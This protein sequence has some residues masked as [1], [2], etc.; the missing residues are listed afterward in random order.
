[1]ESSALLGFLGCRDVVACVG[2]HLDVINIGRLLATC[3]SLHAQRRMIM[4]D[5][6]LARYGLV[7]WRRA[8]TRLT[9]QRPLGMEWE[10]RRMHK[11]EVALRARGMPPWTTDDYEAWWRVEE[12]WLSGGDG[13]RRSDETGATGAGHVTTAL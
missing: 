12:R 9:R 8:L 11:F 4:F 1:M 13:G 3:L 7:F 5:V 6:A 2:E 10:L